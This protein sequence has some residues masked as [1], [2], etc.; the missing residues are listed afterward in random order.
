[1]EDK[2]YLTAVVLGAKSTPWKVEGRE[3]VKNIVQVRRDGVILT[4]P[5]DKSYLDQ[6]DKKLRF[7]VVFSMKK[8]TNTDVLIATLQ[9]GEAKAQG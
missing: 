5:S 8:M 2:L 4:F 1:M 9:N 7:E 3:G 6:L